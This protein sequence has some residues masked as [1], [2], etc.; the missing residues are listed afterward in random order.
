MIAASDFTFCTL[1]L[2]ASGRADRAIPAVSSAGSSVF[3]REGT[4]TGRRSRSN[5][6]ACAAV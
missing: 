5:R 2:A 6:R 3:A 1:A 4:S